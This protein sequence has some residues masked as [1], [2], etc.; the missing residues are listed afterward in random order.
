VSLAAQTVAARAEVRERTGAPETKPRAFADFHI[1]TR[2]SRDSI[3]LWALQTY[4]RRREYQA[5]F[6]QL[7]HRHLTVIHL[8]SPR[9]TAQWLA[10]LPGGPE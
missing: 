9:E 5:L 3:L 6:S 7:E 10:G 4:R 1:H 8:R 2:F